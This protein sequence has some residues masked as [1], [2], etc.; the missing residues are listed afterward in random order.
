MDINSAFGL[1]EGELQPGSQPLLTSMYIMEECLEFIVFFFNLMAL[2]GN[3]QFRD[4]LL[5]TSLL[6]PLPPTQ[7]EKRG[8]K[9][10]TFFLRYPSFGNAVF[11]YV[12]YLF[13]YCFL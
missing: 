13:D 9:E 7:I 5:T 1:L 2:L 3:L 11:S 12:V 10:H 4:L 8:A 6:T